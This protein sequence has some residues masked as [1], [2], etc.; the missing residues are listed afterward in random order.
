MCCDLLPRGVWMLDYHCQVMT[1]YRTTPASGRFGSRVRVYIYALP[2]I[3]RLQPAFADLYPV[4]NWRRSGFDLILPPRIHVVVPDLNHTYSR[5][6]SHA[7]TESSPDN[8]SSLRYGITPRQ[9]S[10]KS[11]LPEVF[12]TITFFRHAGSS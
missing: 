11:T 10:T 9:A 3:F 8:F 4:F 1:T 12:W 2:R 7:L 5:R 6:K